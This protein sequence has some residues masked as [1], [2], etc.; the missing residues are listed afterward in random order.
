VAGLPFAGNVASNGN[1]IR[2]VDNHDVAVLSFHQLVEVG[3]R[4]RIAT[5]DAMAAKFPK[6]ADLANRHP[7]H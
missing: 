3:L 7:C 6:L 4:S 1:V 2:R 5:M